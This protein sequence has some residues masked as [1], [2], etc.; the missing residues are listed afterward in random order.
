MQRLSKEQAT[1]FVDLLRETRPAITSASSLAEV[2]RAT[3]QDARWLNMTPDRRFV[4]NMSI[5]YTQFCTG[6]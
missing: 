1:A 6:L 5:M 3:G 2:E 4:T